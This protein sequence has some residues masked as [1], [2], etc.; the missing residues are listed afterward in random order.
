MA[1]PQEIESTTVIGVETSNYGMTSQYVRGITHA[2]FQGT[3]EVELY[4][5]VLQASPLRRRGGIIEQN[6][7]IFNFYPIKQNIIDTAGY[8]L[9]NYISRKL[10]ENAAI[11]YIFTFKENNILHV[12]IVINKLDREAR[13]KIYD[14]EYTIL[15]H[16]KDIYFDFHVIYRDDRDINDLFPRK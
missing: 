5:S 13:D 11:E 16:F 9:E 14:I 1:K 7:L 6:L 12:W 4:A 10:S 15:E 8:N 2:K 3:D